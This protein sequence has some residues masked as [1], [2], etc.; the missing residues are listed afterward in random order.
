MAGRKASSTTGRPLLPSG[1]A[2][3]PNPEPHKCPGLWRCHV[4]NS[5][6]LGVRAGSGGYWGLHSLGSAWLAESSDLAECQAWLF[7]VLDPQHLCAIQPGTGLQGKVLSTVLLG[8]PS[9]FS[10]TPASL[11]S[12]DGR[13]SS[14]LPIPVSQNPCLFQI[15][16]GSILNPDF[17]VSPLLAN[18]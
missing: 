16:R 5:H 9:E 12:E 13:G 4:A 14:R 3:A 8:L 11:P 6:L 15:P 1:P 17:S 2:E 7:W 10:F 18:A